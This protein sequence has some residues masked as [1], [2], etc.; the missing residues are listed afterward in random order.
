MPLKVTSSDLGENKSF[1]LK[2]K[3]DE[4]GIMADCLKGKALACYFE[5]ISTDPTNDYIIVKN[6]TLSM[7]QGRF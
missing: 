7:F 5:L 1:S 2:W 6:L 3:R 4:S